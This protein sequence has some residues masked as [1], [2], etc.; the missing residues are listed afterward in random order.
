M[1]PNTLLQPLRSSLLVVALLVTAVVAWLDPTLVLATVWLLTQLGIAA[2]LG[3]WLD[4]TLFHY[5]KP[6]LMFFAADHMSDIGNVS[7]SRSMRWQ[8]A[9]AALRCALLMASMIIA[10]GY[11]LILVPTPGV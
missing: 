8:A 3:Y 4:R 5:A 9:L 2:S 7:G 1:I 11:A 6:R 10:L